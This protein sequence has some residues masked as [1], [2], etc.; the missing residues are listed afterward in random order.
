M[1][2]M[3]YLQMKPA[4]SPTKQ[5]GTVYILYLANRLSGLN[6]LYTCMLLCRPTAAHN[7]FYNTFHF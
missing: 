5:E 3:L 1:L 6:N 7:L 2:S 4:G